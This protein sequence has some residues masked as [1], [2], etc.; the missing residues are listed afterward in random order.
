MTMVKNEF[1][2]YVPATILPGKGKEGENC[3]R[4]ACQVDG[5]YYFNKGTRAWYCQQCAETIEAS[6]VYYSKDP[7]AE[8]I[9]FD[10][11]KIDKANVWRYKH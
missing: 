3:N 2:A 4:T 1:G 7:Y 10:G 8:N 9:L 11:L 6:A 5:A